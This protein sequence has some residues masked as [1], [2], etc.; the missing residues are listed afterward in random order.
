MKKVLL[1]IC[2][3]ICAAWCIERL[4]KEGFL[5]EGLFYN[6][7]IHPRQEYMRR[8]EAAQRI[9]A[10]SGITMHDSIYDTHEWFNACSVYNNESEG[11]KRCLLCYEMRLD[12]TLQRARKIGCTYF[13]TTLTI[14]PHKNSSAIIAIGNR[15]GGDFFLPVDF[16]KENG[17]MRTMQ[18][19]KQHQLYRQHYCGCTYSDQHVT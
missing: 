13:A 12:A 11:G 16:K 7:N 14:S 1:H 10:L 15:I 4:Q 6:P 18:I 3:G 17:F 8:Y 19:A 2:C 5:V 9:C